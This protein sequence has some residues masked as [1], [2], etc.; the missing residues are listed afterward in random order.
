[1]ERKTKMIETD[2]YV[3]FDGT[4]FYNEWDCLRY[5]EENFCE[6]IQAID[7]D[8]KIVDSIDDAA[9]FTITN[10]KQIKILN[11]LC[12]KFCCQKVLDEGIYV[13]N[14]DEG[15]FVKYFDSYKEK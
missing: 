5:E 3:A 11:E 12:R 1:M 13:W 9:I 10:K 15:Y 7:F 6:S 2:I 8:G 14:D 4:E